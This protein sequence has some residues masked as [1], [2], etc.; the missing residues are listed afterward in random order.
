MS[1]AGSSAE[2]AGLSTESVSIDRLANISTR[3]RTGL[4]DEVMIAGFILS[5]T[6]PRQVLIRAVG[7]SLGGLGVNGALVQS[8][9]ELY[10]GSTKI[11][12]GDDWGQQP[13][14]NLI[15]AAA[16]QTGAF[17]LSNSSHDAAL[18]VTLDPGTYTAQVRGAT[19]ATGVALV[20]VYDTGT[21]AP[22]SVAP[23]LANIS[24]R[25]RVGTGDEILIAGIIVGGNTPK[26]LLIRAI[27]PTLESF[28]VAGVLADPMLTLLKGSTPIGSNDDWGGDADLAEVFHSVG[29]F[30]LP[31][32]SKDAALVVT[33]APG[34]YTAQVRGKLDSTGVAIVEVYELPE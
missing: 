8:H 23:K 7:P 3:G 29:A 34:V 12:E 33:L 2:F 10:R 21:A 5:G 9:L 30:E 6:G 32:G 13:N 15:A 22:G 1:G 4:G 19:G 31:S 25:G 16:A 17:N 20:E 24:T 18:L 11:A 28:G 27:G 26:R 14:A